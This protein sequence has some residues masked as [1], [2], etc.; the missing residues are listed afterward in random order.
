LTLA[1][2]LRAWLAVASARGE[3]APG[4][5]HALVLGGGLRADSVREDLV[6]P[7]TFS[8]PGVRLLAGYRGEIGPGLLAVD[9]AVGFA[10]LFNRYGHQAAAIDHDVDVAWTVPVRRTTVSHWA[11]GPMLALAGRFNYLFS[12]DDAHAYWL[13]AQWLGPAARYGRRLSERWRVEARAALSVL[14]FEGRPP[15]YRYHKQ[16]T[17]PS[18]TYPFTAPYGTE[19]FV[20]VKDLQAVRLD[21]AFR[22]TVYTGSDVGRGWSFGL[23]TRFIRTGIPVTNINLTVC[24]YAARAWGIR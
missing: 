9:G 21:V 24:A 22:R 4:P 23:D 5:R 10:F 19:S 8:G 12:W 11:L 13:A 6:V 3:E 2:L 16:E 17:R 7:L 14:G 15:T 1:V 20:T 18:A